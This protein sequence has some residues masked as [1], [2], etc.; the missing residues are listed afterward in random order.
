MKQAPCAAAAWPASIGPPHPAATPT[1]RRSGRA[2][3]G[4]SVTGGWTG[5]ELG[6]KGIRVLRGALRATTR[7]ARLLTSASC[8]RARWLAA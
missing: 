7:H 2:A 6:A 8:W 1:N 4:Y 3:R 5:L